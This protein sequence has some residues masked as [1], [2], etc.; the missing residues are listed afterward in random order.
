[1]S[2]GCKVRDLVA[3]PLF[4]LA[5]QPKWLINEKMPRPGFS[6]DALCCEGEFISAPDAVDMGP[7]DVANVE[8]LNNW[9]EFE[10]LS[11]NPRWSFTDAGQWAS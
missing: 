9:D 3:L 5:W 6:G 4:L 2:L 1:M 7:E 8:P 10:R 11:G